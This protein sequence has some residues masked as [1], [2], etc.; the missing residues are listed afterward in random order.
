MRS[1]QVHGKIPT[2]LGR[3]GQLETL[4]LEGNWLSGTIPAQL[5]NLVKARKFSLSKTGSVTSA[6]YLNCCLTVSSLFRTNELSQKL[7][8]GKSVFGSMRAS[9]PFVGGA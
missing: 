4:L 3:L 8:Y 7:S 5:G 9:R 6:N 2:E 1:S